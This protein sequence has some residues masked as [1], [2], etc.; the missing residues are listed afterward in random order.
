M[1]QQLLMNGIIAGSIYASSPLGFILIYLTVKFL[2][3]AHG[4]V[5]TFFIYRF[6]YTIGCDYQ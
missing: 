3:F 5:Y 1:V 6:C 2:H 4:A